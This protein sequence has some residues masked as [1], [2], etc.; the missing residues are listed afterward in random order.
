MKMLD[1]KNF[2]LSDDFLFGISLRSISG[3][4]IKVGDKNYN[5]VLDNSGSYLIK[6][7]IPEFELTE[8]EFKKFKK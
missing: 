4:N 3:V 7:F 1:K 6:E 5:M 8:E 2:D